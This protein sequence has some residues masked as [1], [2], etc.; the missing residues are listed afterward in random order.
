VEAIDPS[1]AAFVAA[2]HHKD[3]ANIR[4]TQAAI[5]VIPFA[6][7]TF[8]LAICLGVLQHIPDTPKALYALTQ[9]VRPGGHLLLYLYYALDNRGAGYRLLHAVSEI[10]RR[11]ISALPA[12]PR[13]VVCEGIAVTVYLPLVTVSRVVAPFSPSLADTLPLGYYRDKSFRIMRNDA[14]D[15][16][17][18]PLEQRF[19]RSEIETMLVEAGMDQIHFSDRAPFW[20]C[21]SR[22][23]QPAR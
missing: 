7:D 12:T 14:L 8:D 9:K 19:S 23:A 6:D 2:A 5:D 16:F 20:H 11:V 3:Q 1:K 4:F 10:F 18:T 22:R 15:R 17:G 13:K 21:L